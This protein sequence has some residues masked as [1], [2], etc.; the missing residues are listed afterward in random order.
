MVKREGKSVTSAR[1]SWCGA[2][3]RLAAR[4]S[5]RWGIALLARLLIKERGRWSKLLGEPGLGLWV[6]GLW[7][8]RTPGQGERYSVLALSTAAFCLI[9]QSDKLK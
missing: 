5:R 8:A 7:K 4:A 9:A 1:R 2:L 6:R 3:R